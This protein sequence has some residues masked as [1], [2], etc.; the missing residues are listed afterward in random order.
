[1]YPKG[2]LSFSEKMSGD[3][4]FSQHCDYCSISMHTYVD[5]V[6]EFYSATTRNNVVV[7]LVWLVT[8]LSNVVNRLLWI[9]RDKAANTY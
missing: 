2:I 6:C 5:S 7:R 9:N 3:G 4:R 8:L 1:M